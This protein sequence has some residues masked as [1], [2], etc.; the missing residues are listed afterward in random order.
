MAAK[1]A[2]AVALVAAV[3]IAPVVA[4]AQDEGAAPS[5][6]QQLFDQGLKDMLEGR[7]EAACAAL[8]QSYEIEPL[9]GGM[10]TLAECELKAGKLLTARGHYQRY[11]ALFDAL[12]ADRQATQQGRRERAIQQIAAIDERAPT[13]ILRLP[14]DAPASTT[15]TFDGE[16]VAPETLT[17]ARRVDPGAHRVVVTLPTGASREHVYTVAEQ[18]REAFT[19]ELPES[20][21]TT[22]TTSEWTTMHTGALVAG[23]I[24]VVGLLVGGVTGGLVFAEKSTISDNCNG[25]RC[26]AEGKDAGDTAQGLATVSTIGFALGGVG[27]ATGAILWLLAPD[28][29]SSA[30]GDGHGDTAWRP[31]IGDCAAGAIVGVEGVW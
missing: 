22:S 9:A 7:Y 6:A 2:L 1:L 8:A 29:P 21:E 30:D 4:H 10:F 14:S 11:M 12:P 24:G 28:G 25:P 13:I 5:K 18:D 3:G 17:H 31:F 26:N 15:V 20:S 16:P 27:L 19:L 23:G